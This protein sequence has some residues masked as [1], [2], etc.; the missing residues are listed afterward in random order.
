MNNLN[1]IANYLFENPGARYTQITRHLCEKKNRTW[2]PGQYCRYFTVP[3]QWQKQTVYAHR[4]WAKT[5]CGG[6]MLTIPGYGY[7]K[8]GENS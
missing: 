2:G 1:H 3:C 5:P 8:R 6:W 7:V 4:L